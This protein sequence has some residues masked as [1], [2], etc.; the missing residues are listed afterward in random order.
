MRPQEF[1]RLRN[2]GAI[3]EPVSRRREGAWASR[4]LQ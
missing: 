4:L 2:A 1:V 3:A